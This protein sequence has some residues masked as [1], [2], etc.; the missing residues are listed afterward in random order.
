MIWMILFFGL[1]DSGSSLA[2]YE[3]KSDEGSV[4]E[5]ILMPSILPSDGFESISDG[6]DGRFFVKFTYDND[7]R[8]YQSERIVLCEAGGRRSFPQG[9]R[10]VSVGAKVLFGTE[11]GLPWDFAIWGERGGGL[12]AFGVQ[13]TLEGKVLWRFQ[14]VDEGCGC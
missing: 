10:V 12:E 1:A 14:R 7:S 8:C 13:E 11:A 4:I 5:S 3:F 9:G 6:P 2:C